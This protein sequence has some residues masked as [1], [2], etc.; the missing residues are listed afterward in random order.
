[1]SQQGIG[2]SGALI[3]SD[4][5]GCR[6]RQGY[7]HKEHARQQELGAQPRDQGCLT[8]LVRHGVSI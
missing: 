7:S 5:H 2:R 3:Y 4:K 1:L 6:L 8:A